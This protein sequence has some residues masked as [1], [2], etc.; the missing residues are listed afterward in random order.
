MLMR[1]VNFNVVPSI[2]QSSIIE[3]ALGDRL[4]V[5]FLTVVKLTAKPTV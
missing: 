3:V 2:N 4:T 5:T 1:I